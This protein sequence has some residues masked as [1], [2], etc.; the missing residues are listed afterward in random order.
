MHLI[1]KVVS[2]LS[3]NSQVM[4]AMQILIINDVIHVVY[5]VA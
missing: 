4:S 1:P 2:H 5:I 3:L